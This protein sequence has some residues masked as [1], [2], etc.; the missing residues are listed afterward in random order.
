MNASRLSR[1]DTVL[2]TQKTIDSLADRIEKAFT[3]RRTPWYRG[4]S[5]ARIWSAAATRL[6]QVHRD[7]STV[8]LDP[9]LFVASQPLADAFIDPWSTFTHHAA[10]RRYK[11]RVLQIIR[12]LRSELRREIK[13]VEE[14]VRQGRELTTIIR[15]HDSRFSPLGLYIAAHRLGRPDLAERLRSGT[16]DQHNCCPLYRTACVALFPAELYPVNDTD[17]KYDVKAAHETPRKVASLN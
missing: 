6:W 4:C 8:P 3:L 11:K 16:V 13:R 5:T 9:E 7:D 2:P 15:A 10:G 14:Q 1:I 12:Q 17:R